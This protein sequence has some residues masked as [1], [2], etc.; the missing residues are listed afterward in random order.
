MLRRSDGRRALDSGA[1]RASA[2][3]EEVVM[4]FRRVRGAALVWVVAAMFVIYFAIDPIKSILGA[5]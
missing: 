4:T 5:G 1:A 3:G 2:D